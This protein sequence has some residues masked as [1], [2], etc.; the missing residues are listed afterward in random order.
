MEAG[1][2][3][4]RSDEGMSKVGVPKSFGKPTEGLSAGGQADQ[5]LR[6]GGRT[7]EGRTRG[8]GPARKPLRYPVRDGVACVG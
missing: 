2:E 7:G 5:R 4:G 8:V 6:E 1:A 3:R